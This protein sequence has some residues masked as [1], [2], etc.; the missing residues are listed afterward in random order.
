MPT[1]GVSKSLTRSVGAHSYRTIKNILAAGLD[2]VPL[3]DTA[4]S[5]LPAHDNIRGA[6]YFQGD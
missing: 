3:D 1:V 5:P 6:A 4:P 2:R